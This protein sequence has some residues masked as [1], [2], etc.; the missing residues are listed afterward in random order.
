MGPRLLGVPVIDHWWQTETGWAIAANLLGIEPLP[1]K[2]G[3][4]TMP[5]PGF[6]VRIVERDGTA[7][8][9][10]EKGAIVVRLPLPPGCLPTLGTTTSGSR[11]PT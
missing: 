3:S 9:P 4:P 10:G 5:V 6:D 8:A 1:A 11:R 2:A 7:V